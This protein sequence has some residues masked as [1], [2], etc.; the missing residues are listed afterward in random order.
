MARKAV[1]T[2][3]FVSLLWSSASAQTVTHLR[4]LYKKTSTQITEMHNEVTNLDST[5][6]TDHQGLPFRNVTAAI[7]QRGYSAS[8]FASITAAKNAARD[9]SSYLIIPRDFSPNA[10]LSLTTA[11]SNLVVHDFRYGYLSKAG[12]ESWGFKSVF[13]A[14]SLNRFRKILDS[15]RTWGRINLAEGTWSFDSL[16]ISRPMFIQGTAYKRIKPNDVAY[17][18]S[19]FKSTATTTDKNLLTVNESGVH[20]SDLTLQ[21]NSRLNGH[22]LLTTRQAVSGSINTTL[23]GYTLERISSFLHGG[24]GIHLRGAD[25]VVLREPETFGNAGYGVAIVSPRY[26]NVTNAG[27]TAGGTTNLVFGGRTRANSRGGILIGDQAAP[28]LLG[29]EAI[30][31]TTVGIWLNEG[32]S[33]AWLLG[34]DSELQIPAKVANPRTVGVR[35]EN[36]NGFYMG[37]SYVGTSH[38]FGSFTADAGTNTTTIVDAA[39]INYGP[40]DY[41]V[42]SEVKNNTRASGK[43]KITDYVASTGTITLASAI[44]SQTT[45]DSYTLTKKVN[46]AVLVDSLAS[47]IFVNNN[48]AH[49]G[50]S[51]TTFAV[52]GYGY[53]TF[54]N[55]IN[56]DPADNLK[57][58]GGATAKWLNYNLSSVDSLSGGDARITSNTEI[59]VSSSD[60]IV[61]N[62]TSTQGVELG[63]S[64]GGKVAIQP[65]GVADV[66][67]FARKASDGSN[68]GLRIYYDAN[69]GAGFTQSNIKI[70]GS[71]NASNTV[72]VENPD[73]IQKWSFG[74]PV[75]FSGADSSERQFEIQNMSNG[76]RPSAPSN[77]F[78]KFY[79]RGDTA[80]VL[81]DN[82]VERSLYAGSALGDVVGPASSTDNAVVRF[83]GTT[84]KLVQNTST[85][86][87][88]DAGAFSFA[89]GV[90]QTFNPNGTSA[91]LNVGSQAGDPS[92]PANGDLWYDGTANELTARINGANVALGSGGGSGVTPAGAR[93][94]TG[95]TS[96]GTTARDTLASVYALYGK[97]FLSRRSQSTNIDTLRI[98]ASGATNG[99]IIRYSDA[100][101][102]LFVVDSTGLIN[103]ASVDSGSVIN[104][105]IIG[106]D[107]RVSALD[108]SKV[109][110]GGLTQADLRVSSLD[111]SRVLNGGLTQA[112]L[113]VSS[114][115]SSRVLNGGLTQ[116]D[117]RVSSLDSTRIIN[118]GITGADLRV[119]II[120]STKAIDGGI[121]TADLRTASVTAAKLA[122]SGVTAGS[123]TSADITVDI[124]GR[125]T[126][127]ANG[128]GG[129][130]ISIPTARAKTGWTSNGTTATDTLSRSYILDKSN[131]QV[132]FV[133]ADNDSVSFVPQSLY[134]IN[135]KDATTQIWAVDSTGAMA[136]ADGV[137]Q[138]F[139]PSA[140]NAGINVGSQA[141][142]PSASAVGDIWLNSTTNRLM[143]KEETYNFPV[144]FDPSLVYRKYEDWEGGAT[145][146]SGSMGVDWL[147][148]IAT[149]GTTSKEAGEAGAPGIMRIFCANSAGSTAALHTDNDIYVLNGPY[150]VKARIRF[151]TLG[152]AGSN[153][154]Y[155]RVGFMDDMGATIP[156]D[157]A[158]IEFNVDSSATRWRA[159]TGNGGTR[160]ITTYTGSTVSSATWYKL[161][162]VPNSG[163]TSI[164]F[165]VDGTTIATHTTNIPTGAVGFAWVATAATASTTKHISSD[166]VLIQNLQMNR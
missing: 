121:T 86:T 42:G 158:W 66:T 113:R 11:D 138:T 98:D 89:D 19:I 31:D 91:G 134:P 58:I 72:S 24:D 82:N 70:G 8:D 137:K 27:N 32:R 119:S 135:Y 6:F 143:A 64:G 118:S 149:S 112:D 49:S 161:E 101:T 39:L 123:Y 52:S 71:T 57:A 117:L 7:L 107:I 109:L 141:G 131:L 163:A 102:L 12:R 46:V 147:R 37:Q 30:A 54:I 73:D 122:S 142:N 114:L 139:N 20:L 125:I 129:S 69:S 105:T 165:K 87:L 53:V 84:G 2:L 68:K 111:S 153:G 36:Y 126:A 23:G 108:S 59:K 130:G 35:V 95:W 144:L 159:I 29:V 50:D 10:V 156:T 1:Q 92:A 104:G 80:Y 28:L 162:I 26:D 61:I 75:R 15:T 83:D 127:A 65:D 44:A 152:T 18:G 145:S 160:T 76:E 128:S 16:T 115:D 157:G 51:D 155:Y 132:H 116:A 38:S 146:T 47:G 17:G 88:S 99:K 74:V 96:D 94:H 106:A 164:D 78:V 110:N 136:L 85:T 43:I 154:A 93:Q 100:G 124:D 40:N 151:S 3:L 14:D 13:E 79:S 120:D 148:T 60:S 140:T 4:N 25:G 45:G 67:L 48:M 33:R 5:Y 22:G 81:D 166:Y 90:T 62:T 41:F 9:S 55:N 133:D 63:S 77:G 150:T 34:V 103:T 56:F 21:G 97:P